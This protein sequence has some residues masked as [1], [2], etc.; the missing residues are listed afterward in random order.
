MANWLIADIRSSAFIDH[1]T[2]AQQGMRNLSGSWKNLPEG[3]LR[4]LTEDAIHETGEGMAAMLQRV[5]SQKGRELHIATQRTMG[6]FGGVPGPSTATRVENF[7]NLDDVL[8]AAENFRQVRQQQEVHVLSKPT[9]NPDLVGHTYAD[10]SYNTTHYSIPLKDTNPETISQIEEIAKQ[11]NIAGM[12][13]N[14]DTNEIEVYF[15]G[16]AT[17]AG[18]WRESADQFIENVIGG[19]YGTAQ[20]NARQ[21]VRRLHPI[22]RSGVWGGKQLSDYLY[23]STGAEPATGARALSTLSRY[24]QPELEPPDDNLDLVATGDP[25]LDEMLAKIYKRSFDVDWIP[26]FGDGTVHENLEYFSR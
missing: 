13:V 15:A 26:L 19:G 17:D 4:Q 9:E 5:P 23:G 14:P 12:N 22:G 7:Q 2:E 21:T 18:Q 25:E 10:G 1:A 11:H 24:A 8:A 16:D 20:R 6:R 3:R